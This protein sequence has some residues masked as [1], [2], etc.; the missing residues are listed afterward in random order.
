MKIEKKQDGREMTL[1]PAGRLDT[2]TAPQL[3]MEIQTI[4]EDTDKLILDFQDLEYLSS[5]GLRVLLSAH[6]A[7]MKKENGGM[8][9]R[10]VNETIHEV[11]E[12][13]GFLDILNV[14]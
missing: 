4:L 8:V 9:I 6:K 14:E 1:L 2:S 11:F 10:N 7:F 5:A 3:D 13:T 12:V